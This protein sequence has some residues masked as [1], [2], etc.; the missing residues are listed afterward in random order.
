MKTSPSAMDASPASVRRRGGRLLAGILATT[1]LVL[2]PITAT[3]ALAAEDEP[4]AVVA[5]AEASLAGSLVVG[6]DV[7]AQTGAWTP[8]EATLGYVWWHSADPYQAPVEGVDQNPGAAVIAGAES[9]QLTLTADLAGQ[10]V[11]AVVTGTSGD[12]TPASIVAPGA[13]PVALPEITGVPG[14]S[15]QGTAVVDQVLTG[16]LDGAQPSDTTVTYAW[17]RNGSPIGGAVDAT[18]TAVAEDLGASLTVHATFAREGH[19]STTSS[20]TAV[21]IG[22]A[23]IVTAPIPTM[24][25]AVRVDGTVTAHPGAWPA[26]TTF[27]YSW[28]LVDSKGVEAV[29]SKTA[30]TY[31]PIATSVGKKLSVVVTARVPGY[32][33]KASRS[34]A[35]TIAPGV[36]MTAPTP[37]I[38]GSAYVGATLTAV[39]KTWAPTATLSL[40]WKRNGVSISGATA[41]T[42]RLTTTDYGKKITVTVVAK[43]SGYTTTTR[44]STATATVTKPF[45]NVSSPKIT[46]TAKVG[47]VLTASVGAWSPG[48]T[49][50][51]QWKR[52]GVAVTG[53][54]A[55]TYTLTTA[56]VGKT[57]TVTVTY[58]RAGYFTRVLTS[59][60]TAPVAAPTTMTREGMFTV[61]VQIAPGTY[62][63]TDTGAAGYDC[64]F[65]RRMNT[66]LGE[67]DGLLGF[68]YW[69]DYAMGGQKVVTISAT[70]K[71]FFT[72]GCGSWKPVTTALRT[73]VGDG[74]WVV[75]KQMAAGLWQQTGTVDLRDC[76]IEA[77]RSFTGDYDTDFIM[78]GSL[79]HLGE[80]F[81]ITTDMKGFTAQGCGTFKRVGN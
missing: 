56:D 28:R 32:H 22:R 1:A 75:G 76:Y 53:K 12:L 25:G 26:G 69:W 11:W 21:V 58:S 18:Y 73:S 74:T 23:T 14:V 65:E 68:W 80:V 57:M 42:Y 30:S 61:G 72:E 24:S 15:I 31:T 64:Y 13:T 40:Q 54:T 27:T 3:G 48:P 44:T 7:T 20:S 51:Y 8:A 78:Y 34:A 10:Y 9:A 29:S 45:T 33:A 4:T 43:R 16:V 38:T 19:L 79:D 5:P 59:A 60:P 52:N 50:T 37:V 77:L 36:F 81:R 49:I 63:S 17:H 71:Y 66:A 55:K 46:G 67:D 41:S 70:D 47:F 2:A 6:G 35:V 39:P 62:Y